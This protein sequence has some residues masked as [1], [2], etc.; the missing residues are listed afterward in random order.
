MTARPL[1]RS[2]TEQAR[3]SAWL[4]RILLIR[5]PSFALLALGSLAIAIILGAFFV[6]GEYTRKARVTGILAP[7]QGVVRII[8]LQ[9]GIV[10]AAHVREGDEVNGEAP[11]FAITDMR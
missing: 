10:T 9:A 2:E 3:A 7:A 11:L 5:P 1:F 6:F 8:A 4:G